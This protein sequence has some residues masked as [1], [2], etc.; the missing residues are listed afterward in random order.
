[1]GAWGVLQ[2]GL[3]IA[4]NGAIDQADKKRAMQRADGGCGRI[5]ARPLLMAI[6][7]N[8]AIAQTLEGTRVDPQGT[9]PG[10]PATQ[11]NRTND[12][13]CDH[14]DGNGRSDG[15]PS[16]RTMSETKF[17]RRKSNCA[18]GGGAKRP[19]NDTARA[20]ALRAVSVC[21][22]GGSGRK[23]ARRPLRMTMQVGALAPNPHMNDCTT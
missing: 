9:R 15:R 1:M 18:A 7:I 19:R 10:C 12:R 3:K 21:V 23:T 16:L 6:L 22:G 11:P 2:W 17:R 14:R 5:L 4:T 8:P 13:G 20:R